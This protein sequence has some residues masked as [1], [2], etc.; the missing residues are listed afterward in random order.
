MLPNAPEDINAVAISPDTISLSWFL[1]TQMRAFPRPVDYRILYQCEYDDKNTWHFAEILR[2]RPA[3]VSPIKY[4]LT[5]LPYGHS[6]CDIRVSVR[7]SLADPKDEDMWS[8][9]ASTTVRTLSKS[10]IKFVA[11]FPGLINHFFSTRK[12]TKNNIWQL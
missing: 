7:S 2:R 3:S 11:F 4:N 8:N 9:N 12:S 5:N 10:K 6:L 1:P